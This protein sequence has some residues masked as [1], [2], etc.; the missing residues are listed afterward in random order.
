[1]I[2]KFIASLQ[3]KLYKRA[4]FNLGWSSQL[5]QFLSIFSIAENLQYL[6]TFLNKLSW[7]VII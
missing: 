3:M 4:V 7:A 1:M 2:T 6:F 5:Y